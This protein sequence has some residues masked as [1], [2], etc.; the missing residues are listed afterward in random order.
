MEVKIK[1]LFPYNWFAIQF[2]HIYIDELY[3]GKISAKGESVIK[4]PNESSKIS[5]KL[6][7]V[8]RT[9]IDLT[10]LQPNQAIVLYLN[11]HN[12]L[13]TLVNSLRKGYLRGALLEENKI[14]VFEK[15]ILYADNTFIKPHD[16]RLSVLSIIL[17]LIV[18]VLSVIDNT[19]D[20]NDIIFFNGLML[21]IGHLVYFNEKEV[22]LSFF[23]ARYIATILLFV[24]SI[25]FISSQYA[26]IKYAILIFTCLLFLLYQKN[27]KDKKSIYYKY[28][29]DLY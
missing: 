16:Y 11:R 17:S 14:N 12:Y 28:L 24:L 2:I 20:F 21:L 26:V 5:F 3:F 9:S 15:E 19:S 6:S 10:P 25:F 22:L 13:S 29:E 7:S 23:K 27:I 18:L 1:I 4:I 8:Y